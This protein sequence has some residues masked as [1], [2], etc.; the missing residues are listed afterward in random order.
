MD[1][2]SAGHDEICYDSHNCPLCETIKDRDA[3]IAGLNDD[4]TELGKQIE[5]LQEQ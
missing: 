2:C 4:V 5:E 1:L 3:E